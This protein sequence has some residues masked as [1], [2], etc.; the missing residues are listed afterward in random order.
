MGK[1]KKK[2][3]VQAKEKEESLEE[4]LASMLLLKDLVT[5]AEE[6]VCLAE[7]I[8]VDL[9]G[10][11]LERE[12]ALFLAIEDYLALPTNDAK[13]LLALL[14]RRDET[15][16]NTKTPN[17]REAHG[18]NFVGREDEG[19]DGDL[20]GEGE[21]ELCE[22]Y[23]RLTKHHLIPKSTWPRLTSRLGNAGDAL[24]KNDEHRAEMILGPGLAHFLEPLRKLGLDKGTIRGLL[25]RTCDICRPCH[26][27]I[28]RT[29]DNLTLANEYNTVENLLKDE[30]IYKFAKF[31]SKQK[32]G[33]YSM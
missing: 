28:H 27:A 18:D 16:I 4:R 12:S 32:T 25:Q 33:K 24:S 13:A 20:I 30:K 31:A 2:K 6:S 3:I 9:E 14:L 10:S 17:R 23:I 5:S 19:D 21:C 29:H 8:I 7:S 1:G 26:S 11:D 22:R 15:D